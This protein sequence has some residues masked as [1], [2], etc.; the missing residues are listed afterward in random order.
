[1]KYALAAAFALLV[2]TVAASPA[3]AHSQAE[4]AEWLEDWAGRVQTSGGLSN[5]LLE[6]YF[7]FRDTH[8]CHF[9]EC[10][11]PR[12]AQEVN[13]SRDTSMGN[14]QVEQWRGLV[15]RHFPANAVDTMLCIMRFESGGNPTA[16]NP[17]SGA[18]GLFQVMPFWWAEFGG[19]R[20]DPATNVRVANQIW[21]RQ[22]YRAW[23]VYKKGRC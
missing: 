19:D 14:G 9:E 20:F 6:E 21:Q 16:V 17:S 7:E 15:S 12:P 10:S 18:A 11:S 22:G 2:V 4:V 1:M 5:E 23:S 3:T 13:P 8:I